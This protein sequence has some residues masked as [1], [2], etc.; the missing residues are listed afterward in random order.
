MPTVVPPPIRPEDRATWKN[1]ALFA[2]AIVS[3]TLA[4]MGFA[5]ADPFDQAAWQNT[6]NV[7]GAASYAV[8][9]IAILGIH[10]LGH[11]LQCRRRGVSASPP[12][13]LPG[14]PIPGV[15]LLPFI[16]TFGAFIKMRPSRMYSADLLAI[17]AWGPLAG[18]AVTL[19]VL[20][21]GVALSDVRV[22]PT[23]SDVLTLGDNLLMQALIYAFHGAIPAGS[24]LWLHPLAM[25]G[26]VG[27][28]LT[29]L[30]LVPMGQLD[31]GHIAFAILGDLQQRLAPLVFG[32]VILLG[33]LA[34]P[35]WLVIA[36]LVWSMGV[37]HPDILN[38]RPQ[39]R[40]GATLGLTCLVIFVLTFSP[41]PIKGLSLPEY[42]GWW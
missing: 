31:G 16:G 3:T 13:F 19:P 34:F 41:A 37:K 25:A 17:G 14:I 7:F 10:E 20:V 1:W 28:F 33:I 11:F 40:A 21:A 18:F 5:G 39:G 38:D 4:G 42:L 30:N 36:A 26:W 24:D 32:A 12:F 22:V 2:A 9:V 29:A 6:S 27:C 35:G 23:Q 15:G 8:A